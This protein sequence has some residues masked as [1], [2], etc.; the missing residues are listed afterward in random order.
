LRLQR[1]IAE[2][3]DRAVGDAG[4]ALT[5]PVENDAVDLLRVQ[6]GHA[7]QRG[8]DRVVGRRDDDC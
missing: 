1:R 6:Q 5:D 7:G 2:R 3:R 8:V 4:T